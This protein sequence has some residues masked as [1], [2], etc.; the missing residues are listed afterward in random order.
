MVLFPISVHCSVGTPLSSSN[1]PLSYLASFVAV[2]YW[3]HAFS[4][5]RLVISVVALSI[6]VASVVVS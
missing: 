3:K 2:S 5:M 6:F 1:G 4:Q